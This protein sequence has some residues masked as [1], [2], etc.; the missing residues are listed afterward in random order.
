MINPGFVDDDAPRIVFLING[1]PI[2]MFDSNLKM[3]LL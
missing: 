2:M 3:T 1:Y